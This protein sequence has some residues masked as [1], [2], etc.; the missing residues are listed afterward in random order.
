[1]SFRFLGLMKYV[2]QCFVAAA[3]LY[4]PLLIG[5]SV[6]AGHAADTIDTDGDSDFHGSAKK[7]VLS[8]DYPDRFLS[9][10]VAGTLLAQSEYP[11]FDEDPLS[12]S[13]KPQKN[14]P[15]VEPVTRKIPLWGE[16]IREM[17]YDLPLPFGTGANFVWMDQG[18][19][20]RELTIGIGSRSAEPEGITFSNARSRNTAATIRLDAWLLPF[21]NIYGL[22][23]IVQ[24]NTELD[25][26]V[27]GLTIDVPIIGQVPI[28][29]PFTIPVDVDYDG[30]TYGGGMTLAGGYK[31]LFGTLDMNYTRSDINIT[32]GEVTT[33]TISPRLGILV[34]STAIKGSGAFWI[35]AMYM[36]YKETITDSINFRQIDPALP[37]LTL[38]YEVKIENDDK[39]NFLFGGQWEISKRWQIM[40]EGGLGERKQLILG[41]FFRF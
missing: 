8:D 35:G 23:G 6:S 39:L 40:A 14:E 19:D 21:L 17:G 24:G 34:E 16:K 36:D 7:Q 31:L 12:G 2:N 4:I 33:L 13:E 28:F 10:A 25:V 15:P 22:V 29:D 9:Y 18:V 37:S 41:A 3:C 27:P 5:L 20:I 38:D 30:V 11:I 26:N 1:M 32:N